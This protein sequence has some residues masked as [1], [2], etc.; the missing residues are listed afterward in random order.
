MYEI[1]LRLTK[2]KTPER[3]RS[4]VF[5]DN[6]EHISHIVP[7]FLLLTLSKSIPA[8]RGG[9]TFSRCHNEF[10]RILDSS[11]ICSEVPFI[12]N[13]YHIGTSQLSIDL[14]CKYGFCVIQVFTETYFRID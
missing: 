14:L 4:G 1:C 6:F 3:R 11:K 8:Q 10:K 7:V 9:D 13:L 2:I 12:K 5:T